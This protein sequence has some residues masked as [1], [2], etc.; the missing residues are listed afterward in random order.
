MNFLL[1]IF[2]FCFAGLNLTDMRVLIH[3]VVLGKP[4]HGRI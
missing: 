4:L 1:D 3:G 2:I